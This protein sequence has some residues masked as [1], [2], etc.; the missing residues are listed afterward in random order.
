MYPLD[1]TKYMMKVL[2]DYTGLVKRSNEILTNIQFVK[3]GFNQYPITNT[4]TAM[5]IQTD[6]NANTGMEFH[7]DT[8]IS[9]AEIY[10]RKN[11]S[12]LLDA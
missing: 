10:W 6:T 4:Y 5:R 1:K 9:C 11:Y 8:S 2:V 3:L 12:S 7:I